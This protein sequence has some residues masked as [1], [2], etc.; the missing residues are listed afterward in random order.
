MAGYTQG[1]TPRTITRPFA[2]IDGQLGK[3]EDLVINP[4]YYW[5]KDSTRTL[6]N[7]K[8]LIMH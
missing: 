1:T 8:M 6:A 4:D 2:P 7:K 5:W 3:E